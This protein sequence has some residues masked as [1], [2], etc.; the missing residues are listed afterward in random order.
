M[1]VSPFLRKIGA[2]PVICLSHMALYTI[3]V[4]GVGKFQ[5]EEG[6]K[7]VNALE[8]AG[9]DPSH[10]CGGIARCTTCRVEFFSEEPPVEDAEKE[11]LEEDELLGKARLSCQIRVDRDMR[12]KVLMPAAEQGWEPGP[13]VDP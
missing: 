7:L 13:Q 10:R 6:V 9:A 2:V 8:K 12:V 4:D 3:E 1:T 11:T 5:V